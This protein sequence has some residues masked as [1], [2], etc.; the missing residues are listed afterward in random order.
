MLDLNST[1]AM[2]TI[3]INELN[4]SMEMNIQPEV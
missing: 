4:I 1:R 2:T 3:N